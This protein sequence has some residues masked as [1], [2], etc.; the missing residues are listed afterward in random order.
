MTAYAGQAMNREIKALEQVILEEG[1][2]YAPTD[3]TKL[4]T[5]IHSK[6]SE[7]GYVRRDEEPTYTTYNTSNSGGK[8]FNL[9]K[10]ETA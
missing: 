5:A 1:Y 10:K 7:L 2:I 8:F 4:A 3:L 6:L 9:D